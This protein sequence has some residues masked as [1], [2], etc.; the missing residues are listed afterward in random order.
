MADA[1]GSIPRGLRVKGEI[2]G[3]GALVVEGELEGRV[4]LDALTVQPHGAVNAEVTVHHATIAGRTAGSLT[5]RDRLEVRGSA[6]VE[7]D[8]RT[9]ALIVEEGAVFRGRVHMD[10]GIPEDL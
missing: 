8:V 2:T 9:K 7:G 6:Q 4:E 3:Q 5:A 10:T 1:T